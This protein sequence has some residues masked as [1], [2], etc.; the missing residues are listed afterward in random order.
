MPPSDFKRVIAESP[1]IFIIGVAGDSGSG[2]TTFTRAIREIFGEDLVSTITIDDYHRYDRRER[3]ELGVTPLVPEANRFDLLEEHLGEL[4]A[5]KTIQKPV[6]NHDTG[7]FDPPV[8]FKPTKI[9]IFEGLHPFITQ[10]MRDLIDFKLY[11][12]PD[13]DVKRAWKIKRDVERRGYSPE[14]VVREMA[15]REPDYER[16]VAPQ[17]RF[18][19]A[20]IKIAFSK[21]GR[22]ASEKKNV[23]HVTLCQSKLERSIRDVDLSIDLFPLLSLSQRNFMVEFTTED[24][25]GKAMGALAFDGELNDA[26]VRKLEKNIEIQTQVQPIDLVGSD[27]YLTAGDVAQ[28]ILAW[29]IIN[30]RIF[31][32]S[33]PET[34]GG[35]K[36]ALTG[37]GGCMCGR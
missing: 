35:E 14:A 11:V 33:A 3:K 24:I 10:K 25:G 28:L 31:I 27:G 37:N 34:G 17:C 6:Y 20:V 16:Y 9:L 22:E 36:T 15:E 12:D 4:K 8:A 18:A 1:Y 32:E 5:G 7:R 29:R 13:P 2:K 19:D 30:R 23:Y 21:Y 26:V